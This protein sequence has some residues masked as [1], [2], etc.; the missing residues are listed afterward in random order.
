MAMN[1][2]Q[3]PPFG[4][5]A[6]KLSGT[7]FTAPRGENLQTWVYRVLPSAAHA[8]YTPIQRVSKTSLDQKVHHIPDQIRWD[9]F[10]LDVTSDVSDHLAPER[11][12]VCF[13]VVF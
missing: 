12:I 4:L 11:T 1:Q 6:E 8:K 7:A 5:Y 10:D 13:L 3:K 2:P 9:P